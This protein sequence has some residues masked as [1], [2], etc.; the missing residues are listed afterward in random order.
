MIPIKGVST[1]R[2]TLGKI[3]EVAA[4]M[5]MLIGTWSNRQITDINSLAENVDTS[6]KMTDYSKERFLS[7]LV[8]TQS[9]P[10][11]DTL[12]IFSGQIKL[13]LLCIICKEKK[14]IHTF[15]VYSSARFNHHILNTIS[16]TQKRKIVVLANQLIYIIC[17]QKVGRYCTQLLHHVI[18]YITN[19]TAC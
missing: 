10:C 6:L 16:F 12:S 19:Y 2:I 15:K 7:I 4:Y 8:V 9:F 1:F 5:H 18:I 17:Y 3:T 13:R 14:Y 11:F